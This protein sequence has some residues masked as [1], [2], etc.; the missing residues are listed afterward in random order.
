MPIPHPDIEEPVLAQ[1]DAQD[2]APNFPEPSE[3][4]RVLWEELEKNFDAVS[5]NREIDFIRLSY[6]V[7]SYLSSEQLLIKLKV[8]K[9]KFDLSNQQFSHLA[10]FIKLLVLGETP[11]ALKN[12]SKL[13][14]TKL[15]ISEGLAEEVAFELEKDIFPPIMTRLRELYGFSDLTEGIAPEQNLSQAPSRAAQ[16]AEKIKSAPP[17]PTTTPPSEKQI[18][19][20]AGKTIL[21]ESAEE[22]KKPEKEPKLT[23]PGAPAIES[24]F[25][26]PPLPPYKLGDSEKNRETG[27]KQPDDENHAKK[28]VLE[29]N[30]VDLRDLIA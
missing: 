24:P 19:S 25:Q 23:Q 3:E 10:A 16:V 7:N 8:L 2:Y 27:E 28:V 20:L 22:I 11:D 5:Y 18:D 26:A 1:Y 9:D 21:K 13:L 6:S 14:S 15:V 29:G 17:T 30:I 12:L 4:Q